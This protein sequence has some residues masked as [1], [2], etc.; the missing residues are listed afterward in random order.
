MRM[1]CIVT[2]VWSRNAPCSVSCLLFYSYGIIVLK[3]CYNNRACRLL[4]EQLL[5][6]WACVQVRGL[7]S[8]FSSIRSFQDHGGRDNVLPVSHRETWG[9]ISGHIDLWW[10]EWHLDRLFS[11]YFSFSLPLSFSQCST[12]VC[13]SVTDSIQSQ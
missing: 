2:C 10:T 8:G 5:R 11:E 4:R 13:V 12:F 3:D 7:L 1:V 9:S 6:V